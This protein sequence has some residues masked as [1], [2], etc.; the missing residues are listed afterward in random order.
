MNEDTM[1]SLL[2]AATIVV[3]IFAVGIFAYVLCQITPTTECAM[4]V[5][6]FPRVSSTAPVI[7][8]RYD[9]YGAVVLRPGDCFIEGDPGQD[10]WEAERSM[11]IVLR[12]G[13]FS[14]QVLDMEADGSLL[15]FAMSNRG[16]NPSSGMIGPRL[17]PCPPV[18]TS[19]YRLEMNGT[20]A[21]SDAR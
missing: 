7:K 4:P 1:R 6:K 3:M 11:Y 16:R 2:I 13:R 21:G 19:K 14:I 17:V 10:P 15:K 9:Q 5:K 8:S 12:A 18:L 20:Q